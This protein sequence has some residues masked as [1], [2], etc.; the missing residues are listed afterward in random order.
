M[1]DRIIAFIAGLRAAGVRVSLAETEDAMKATAHMGV[2]DRNA[3]KTALKT[4]LIKERA[5]EPIYETLFPLYFGSGGPPLLQPQDSLTPDQMEMLRAALRALA[6]DLGELLRKLSQGLAPSREELERIARQMGLDR[7]R[8]GQNQQWLTREMLRRLGM[9]DLLDQIERLLQQ[10]AQMGMSAEGLQKMR[11]I[12]DANR[13]ALEGQVKQF[14]GQTLARQLSAQP[15]QKMDGQDL[16]HRPFNSLTESEAREL[17]KQVSRLAARLRAKASLRQK[18]GK[19]PTLDAKRTIRANV[20]FGGVPFDIRHKRRHLKP[21]LAIICDVSTSMRQVVDFLLRLVYEMQD[22]IAKARS[23]AFIDHVEEIS[24]EFTAGRPD[25]AVPKVLHQ[26]PPGYYNTDLGSSLD[27]FTHDY[28][29][30]VDNRTTIIVVGDGR[31]NYNDPRLDR[32][33]EIKR[34]ARRLLWMNPEPVFEWG[35]GDS[36][37]LQYAP[38][39]DSVHQVSNLAEL[40]A[41][42]EHLFEGR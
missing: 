33:E 1:D 10:L 22:Q 24:D 32:F 30:S 38:L 41:A 42:V 28:F 35:T 6:G 31:N 39:C 23:F 36:D 9:Q 12:L 26:I 18:H 19:G 16:M 14:V 40:T 5:D 21:K 34:R 11:E 3:F 8:R 29:D 17:R 7:P 4:T 37:M 2:T 13:E 27:Q 25:V 20:R 15:P